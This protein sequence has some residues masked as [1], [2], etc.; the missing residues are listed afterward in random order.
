MT[1]V[2]KIYEKQMLDC[3]AVD[4]EVINGMKST[5]H[6]ILEESYAKSKQ[7]TY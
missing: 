4:Q 1:P 3:G 2:A 7:T 5:I 6:T